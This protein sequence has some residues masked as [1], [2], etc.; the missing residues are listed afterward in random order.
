MSD[1]QQ[2]ILILTSG[3]VRKPKECTVCGSLVCDS[4]LKIWSD[5]NN[6]NN[7]VFECPM[8]CQKSSDLKES[9]M[10]PI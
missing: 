9:I 2:L 1:L 5:K 10:K 6:Q 7:I 4:C 3:V 8:R